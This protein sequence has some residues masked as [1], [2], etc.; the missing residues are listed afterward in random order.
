MR[1]PHLLSG[2]RDEPPAAGPAPAGPPH[3]AATEGRPGRAVLG[4]A[5]VAAAFVLAQLTLVAPGL[6]LG[7]DETVYVSQVGRQGPAAFLSAPRARGV[8]FLAAPVAAL[9]TSVAALRVWLALLSGLGLFLALR[10]WLPLLPPR[11]LALAGALFATLW[12]VLYYGPQVMPNLWVA[13]G[14]FAAVGFFLRAARAPGEPRPLLGLGAAVAFV[15]L[16]RPPD[17]V[18]LVLVLAAASLLVPA[19]R[20]PVLWGV[21]AAGAAAGGAEWVIEAYVRYGGLAARL[22]RASEIQGELGLYVAVDDH[23]RAL[24]GRTLCRPCDVPWRN[25]VTGLWFLVLPLCV[26]GGVRAAAGTPHRTPAVLA[27][28]AGCALALPYLFTVD[29]AAPRFL[30]PAYVLLA[31]PVALL[32]LRVAD[33]RTR[34]RR[35]LLGV[36]ALALLAHLAIQYKVLDSVTRRVRTDTVTL[37]RIAEQLHARGVRPPCVVSGEDAVRIAYRAGCASRQPGG[38]DA[39]ITPAALARLGERRPVAVLLSGGRPAP[40]FA[41][42]WAAHPLPELPN[43]P[44][45]RMLVSPSAG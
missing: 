9:T 30:F 18:P 42:G 2:S 31:V 1:E 39:S 37:T 5:A 40:E 19:W 22:D 3:A 20:R 7:W 26:A 45:F 21:L 8:S 13:Y 29:Y 25:P 41:R 11:V 10:T 36:C 23:V 28:A 14:A 34:R 27:T 16:M 38:H 4:P 44:G 35:A 32:L 33:A 17:A 6:G 15:A 43:R 24:A 12:T